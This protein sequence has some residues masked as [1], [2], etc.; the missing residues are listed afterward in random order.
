M[1]EIPLQN[2]EKKQPLSRYQSKR[3]K[4]NTKQFVSRT[5]T[6]QQVGSTVHRLTRQAFHQKPFINSQIVA[7]WID[8]IGPHYGYLT[9]PYHL[10]HGVLTIACSSTTATEIQYI[11]E[12]LI[13]KINLYCGRKIISRLKFI[14]KRDIFSS[15]TESQ[16]HSSLKVEPIEISNLPP[17]PLQNALARLG[18]QLQAR[19]KGKN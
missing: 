12:T 10:S 19:K 11:S 15:L 18:G 16:N 7:D 13:E 6:M 5:Y 1:T 3:K 17:G 14:Y 8:I 4:D 2:T 9:S